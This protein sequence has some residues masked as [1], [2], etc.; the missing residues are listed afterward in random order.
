MDASDIMGVIKRRQAKFRER[1][2]SSAHLSEAS[3]V[4]SW[5]AEEYD[6]LIAEIELLYAARRNQPAT[7]QAGAEEKPDRLSKADDANHQHSSPTTEDLVLGDL[8]QS[9]G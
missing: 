6:S 5:I 2:R 1:S 4:D 9:G 3:Q 7:G 8:G